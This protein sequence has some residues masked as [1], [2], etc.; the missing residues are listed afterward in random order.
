MNQNRRIEKE[1]EKLYCG[2]KEVHMEK[3]FVKFRRFRIYVVID[4]CS[5]IFRGSNNKGATDV[6]VET[7]AGCLCS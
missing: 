6:I 3:G 4:V 7:S 2:E 5:R 1:T